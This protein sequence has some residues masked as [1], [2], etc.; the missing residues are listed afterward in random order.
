MS[1]PRPAKISLKANGTLS[2]VFGHLKKD[3][4]GRGKA[5]HDGQKPP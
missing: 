1:A 4:D 2:T 3:V 5:G